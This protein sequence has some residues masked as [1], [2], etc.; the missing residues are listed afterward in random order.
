MSSFGIKS[1]CVENQK[2]LNSTSMMVLM[3]SRDFLFSSALANTRTLS[4]SSRCCFDFISRTV[5]MGRIPISLIVLLVVVVV[6]V[7]VILVMVVVEG[8][9]VGEVVVGG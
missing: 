9:V 4:S 8:I 7:V 1:F 5:G 2:H 3:A 6:V